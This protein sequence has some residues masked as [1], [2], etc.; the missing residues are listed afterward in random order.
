MYIFHQY[1]F[2]QLAKILIF[3]VLLGAI[4]HNTAFC[5]LKRSKTIYLPTFVTITETNTNDPTICQNLLT[6][7]CY[8][9]HL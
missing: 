8:L 3:V 5:E 2:L 9:W 1:F 4:S 6:N 7:E